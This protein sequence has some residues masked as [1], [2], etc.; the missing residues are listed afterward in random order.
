[1]L[2]ILFC[3]VFF[4][5]EKKISSF[6][7]DFLYFSFFLFCTFCRL[8]FFPEQHNISTKVVYCF[9]IKHV[10]LL[11]VIISH[12]I[13]IQWKCVNKM[14]S[15]TMHIKSTLALIEI[16]KKAFCC[17]WRCKIELTRTKETKNNNYNNNWFCLAKTKKK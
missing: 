15:V 8:F 10:T 2:F 17:N 6:N 7:L 4:F 3:F 5:L 14:N 16:H 13:H 9:C 1:M 11:F 12:V